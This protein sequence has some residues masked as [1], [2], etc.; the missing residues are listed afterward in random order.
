MFRVKVGGFLFG[1]RD[2]VVILLNRK[3]ER[4]ILSL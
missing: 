1:E 4:A 2:V 3:V